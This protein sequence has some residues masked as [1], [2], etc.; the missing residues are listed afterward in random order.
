MRGIG[1]SFTHGVLH[2]TDLG[3][4][5]ETYNQF[6]VFRFGKIGLDVLYRLRDVHATAVNH[7]IHILNGVDA[8]FA[9]ASAAQADVVDTGIGHRITRTRLDKR[10]NVLD[11]RQGWPNRRQ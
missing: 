5:N 4:L 1:P 7:T 6:A 8:I 2:D 9:E 11:D 10:R 3:T